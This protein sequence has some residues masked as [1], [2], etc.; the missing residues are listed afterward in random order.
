MN[1]LDSIDIH[2]NTQQSSHLSLKKCIIKTNVSTPPFNIKRL[3]DT[4]QA[5]HESRVGDTNLFL[6]LLTILNKKS[7]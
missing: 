3:I 1:E 6:V 7:S 5:L 4:M 2:D